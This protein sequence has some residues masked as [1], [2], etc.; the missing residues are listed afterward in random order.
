MLWLHE[1]LF[2]FFPKFWTVTTVPSGIVA[3]I[4][5]V[6]FSFFFF[7][8]NRFVFC[9]LLNIY[10]RWYIYCYTNKSNFTIFLQLLTCVNA[11]K[12]C[13]YSDLVY[14]RF[15][16]IDLFSVVVGHSFIFYYFILTYKKLTI[17]VKILWN[18]LCQYNNIYVGSYKYLKEKKY[19][20]KI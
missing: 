11:L 9:S 19:K 5:I 7:S 12:H 4:V 3:T 10:V 17:I 18:L 16:Y 20:W 1:P 13:S 6:F 2:F 8:S 14:S 15:I